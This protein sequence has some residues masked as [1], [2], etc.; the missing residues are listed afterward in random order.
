MGL[1][2]GPTTK[3]SCLS[4]QPLHVHPGLLSGPPDLAVGLCL[5]DPDPLSEGVGPPASLHAQ[6]LAF[7]TRDIWPTAPPSW[8]SRVYSTRYLRLA[9]SRSINGS[10][11]LL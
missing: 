10:A 11:S 4:L 1:S 9:S 8:P 7:Q 5:Q 3:V 2:K 6:S